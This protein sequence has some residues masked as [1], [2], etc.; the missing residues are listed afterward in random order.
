MA[1]GLTSFLRYALIIGFVTISFLFSPKPHSAQ[2]Y[3]GKFYDI[4]A[5]M[6]FVINCDSYEYARV[7]V[8]P[9]A[10]FE[11]KSVRQSRP[12]FIILGSAVGYTLYPVLRLF[13]LN[14]YESHFAGFLLVNFMLLMLSL[15]SVPWSGQPSLFCLYPMSSPKCSSGQHISRC[16]PF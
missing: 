5:H 3:C 15:F 9:S 4:G 1:K 16:L 8:T 11:E 7:S 13:H 2:E 10:L 14:I 12:L 6:G